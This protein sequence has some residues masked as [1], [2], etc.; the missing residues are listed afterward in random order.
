MPRGPY[1]QAE[2]D[3]RTHPLRRAVARLAPGEQ[4]E[5]WPLKTVQMKSLQN[6]VLRGAQLDRVTV[7]TFKTMRGT[8]KIERLA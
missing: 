2:R 3:R 7:K 1:S 5:L 6:V 4:V 8:L